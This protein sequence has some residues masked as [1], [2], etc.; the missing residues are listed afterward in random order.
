MST[1]TKILWSPTQKDQYLTYGSMV[2]L[3]KVIRCDDSDAFKGIQAT[4]LSDNTYGIHV[5]VNSG[6][7][8]LKTVAWYPGRDE[9]DN[10][11]AVGQPNGKIILTSFGQPG[12]SDLVGKEFSP[13]HTRSCVY[14]AWNPLDTNLIA[15]GLEKYRSDPCIL[16]W[17]IHSKPSS[18]MTSTLERQ[19]YSSSLSE[20]SVITK[21]ISELGAGDTTGSL[22]W[23]HKD[24]NT[25]AVGLGSKYIK[26]FD[27]RETSRQH[28]TTNTKSVY[29]ICMDPQNHFRLASFHENQVSV[30]DIRNFDKPI[31]TF[32]ETKAVVQIGWCPTR[33]G[34]LA[35][36]TKETSAV[37]LYDIRHIPVGADELDP[38]IIERNIQCLPNQCTAFSWHPMEE[39]RMLTISQTGAVKDI[40]VH[41]RIPVMW[42]SQFHLSWACG[43]R[44]VDVVSSKESDTIDISER[45]QQRVRKGYGTQ[46]MNVEHNAHV[47]NEEPNLRGMWRW[48]SLTRQLVDESRKSQTKMNMS[49][50]TGIKSLLRQDNDSS[51]NVIYCPW[52]EVDGNILNN[53]RKMRMYTSEER[54]RAIRLCGWRN[55]EM[56]DLFLEELETQTEYT[57]AAAVALFNLK[58]GKSIQILSR[59]AAKQGY[60]NLSAVAM[61]I[62][63]Y[64]E[65]QQTMWR[66]TCGSLLQTVHDPY[67]RAMFCFLA[68]DKENY[69]E[70]LADDNCMTVADRLAFAC[71]YLSDQKLKEYVDSLS[72]RM[73]DQGCLD[74][75][76]LT[77]LT[78]EGVELLQNYVDRTGDIQTAALAAVYTFPCEMS[79]ND[80]VITW[81]ESYREL[82]DRW[83]LWHERA[84]FDIIRHSS[85]SH[86]S[87][88]H[89]RPQAYVSCNFCGKSIA[90]N[91]QA[92]FRL[93]S[94]SMMSMSANKPKIS[95]CPGCRKPLPRC[96]VCL[97][98][99]GTPSGSTL[100]QQTE[101]KDLENKLTP[102]DDWFTWCQTCRHGG[103]ASHI[104]SWFKDHPQCPVTGCDC[105]CATLDHIGRLKSTSSLVPAGKA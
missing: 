84:E 73:K 28:M 9:Q 98:N 74:G 94:R 105:K 30:W 66:R 38:A 4:R 71:I 77:G 48:L 43:R 61:A 76:L 57:K 101:H 82:L 56:V 8:Y 90:C 96:A 32:P 52:Q 50:C 34:F 36:L 26:I 2:N 23:S 3:Y 29:G 55:Q 69:D 7:Q 87:L 27:L 13:K 5:A 79:N 93:M 44:M 17:D 91:T 1:V 11:I 39:N 65:E 19:R 103:H 70:I 72:C 37:K 20:S 60:E 14:L 42:S 75:L 102:L 80:K 21:P 104:T 67:L 46:T 86:S 97:T 68:S 95:C 89:N 15:E 47:V 53:L 40:T 100:C 18:E 6:I 58:M 59:T 85:D 10:L 54:T 51:N 16:I 49:R 22:A 25:F 35:V 83:K 33:M 64:T 24:S 45:I 99:L 78:L 88:R 62:A 92:P 63:G 81:I 31:M 12:G 41:E